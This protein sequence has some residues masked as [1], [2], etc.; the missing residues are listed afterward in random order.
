MSIEYYVRENKLTVP[1]SY[2][3]RPKARA[4]LQYEDMASR[5]SLKIP[6]ITPDIA[7][8]CLRT[9][10]L[11]VKDELLNGNTVNLANFVSFVTTIPVR[12]PLST[13]L[14]PPSRVSVVAKPSPVFT[15]EVAA[16]AT[17][18]RLGV[19][20]VEPVIM[21]AADSATGLNNWM[22]EGFMIDINGANLN[23]N[24][25]DQEQGLFF[26]SPAGNTIRAANIAWLTD[27]KIIAMP[28]IDPVEGPAGKGSVEYDIKVKARYSPAG[29]VKTAEF[30]LLRKTNVIDTE[31]SEL[32]VK[33][34]VS[35][36]PAVVSSYTGDPITARIVAQIRPDNV[37][38]I[39]AGTLTGD[40]G[41]AVVITGNGTYAIIGE[42]SIEIQV[43]DY[44]TLYAN[45]IQYQRYLQEIV[46]INNSE[47]PVFVFN[48]YVKSGVSTSK[49]IDVEASDYGYL[50]IAEFQSGAQP[51]GKSIAI[52]YTDSDYFEYW[53]QP[54]PSIPILVA[55]SFG[56]G[57]IAI[58]NTTGTAIISDKKTASYL[59]GSYPYPSFTRIYLDSVGTVDQQ[60]NPVA[61]GNGMFVAFSYNKM[62]TYQ[63]L[64]SIDDG[65][66]FTGVYQNF[67]DAAFWCAA[68]YGNGD[69]V[70]VSG[71]DSSPFARWSLTY[72][73]NS[74][75]TTR[76][77]MPAL[78]HL[79]GWKGIA[80]GDGKFVACSAGTKFAVLQNGVWSEI[81]V[82]E[83]DWIDIAYL[84][85]KWTAISS[86]GTA[87]SVMESSDLQTWTMINRPDMEGSTL[88]AIAGKNSKNAVILASSVINDAPYSFVSIDI[89]TM[90]IAQEGQIIISLSDGETKA[91]RINAGEDIST[92]DISLSNLSTDF[93][94]YAANGYVPNYRLNDV[95]S[96]NGS[97]D[98]ESI[99]IANTGNN[100]YV[101]VVGAYGNGTGTLQIALS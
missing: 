33:G 87:N 12:L 75:T 62:P 22:R 72:N 25:A 52:V 95:A 101:L 76:Q 46:M 4:V 100:V 98:P 86:E 54:C 65:V 47:Q 18:T 64:R 77:E 23:F 66:S 44:N 74:G 49:Y 7:E 82:Q 28:E 6:N 78:D 51:T 37:L 19:E 85:D 56:F 94:L 88:R 99:Q 45:V 79:F 90:D 21:S 40:L 97:T 83:G 16:I 29:F 84:S 27:K 34:N 80:Y 69:F 26:L 53:E 63:I 70:G 71:Y 36:G 92:I 24:Q 93:D 2:T 31:N 48:S 5:I 59:R 30:N 41:Q 42:V 60:I 20:I 55:D 14:L 58:S 43:V 68:A 35:S 96:E 67:A 32:F 89:D 13:D 11:I 39:S 61:Y 17:Y 91:Y 3:A 57:K 73:A 50:S 81:T 1:I 8:N 15:A 9:M 38:T 10:A